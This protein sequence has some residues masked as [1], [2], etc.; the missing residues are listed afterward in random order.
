MPEDLKASLDKIKGKRGKMVAVDEDVGK[1]KAKK[2]PKPV[3]D[4]LEEAFGTKGLKKVR[5]HTGGY[6]PDICKSLNARTFVRGDNIFLRKGGWP[7]TH[8][9][10][11]MNWRMRSSRPAD[12]KCRPKSQAKSSSLARNR[13]AAQ[14]RLP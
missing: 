11:P 10:W 12:A 1:T 3:I 5:V 14:V 13:Q 8:A 4:A 9:F 7:L 2:L 6:A